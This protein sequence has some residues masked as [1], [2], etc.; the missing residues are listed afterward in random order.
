VTH[1]A[2]RRDQEVIKTITSHVTSQQLVKELSCGDGEGTWSVLLP[3]C[4]R[5]VS[6]QAKSRHSHSVKQESSF[7][8]NRFSGLTQS[9]QYN[10]S[11]NEACWDL[12]SGFCKS[13]KETV[14]PSQM[15]IFEC[16]VGIDIDDK[17]FLSAFQRKVEGN[18]SLQSCVCRYTADYVWKAVP[19]L[20]PFGVKV[21]H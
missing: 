3:I 16:I 7:N 19:H 8:T 2:K 4:S 17:V 9:S 10:G 1:F 13:L 20:E 14:P 5:T 15:K 6:Q 11:F 18:Y 21:S 12:L